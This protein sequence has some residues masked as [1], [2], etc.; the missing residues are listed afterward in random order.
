RR[1]SCLALCVYCLG[2]SARYVERVAPR[3]I[4][5]LCNRPP[6]AFLR[7]DVA[8]W[9]DSLAYRPSKAGGLSRCRRP[10]SAPGPLSLPADDLAPITFALSALTLCRSGEV[11]A[12][13]DKSDQDLMQQFRPGRVQ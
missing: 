2:F 1:R 3:R 10:R 7:A 6:A 12:Q 5:F 9:L 4:Q 13:Q 11:P 8:G